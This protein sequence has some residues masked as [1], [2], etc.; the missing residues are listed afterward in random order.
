MHLDIKPA[1]IVCFELERQ[2]DGLRLTPS[3]WL[4]KADVNLKGAVETHRFGWCTVHWNCR[5]TK[6]SGLSMAICTCIHYM[7]S[8]ASEE[9]VATMQY[10]FLA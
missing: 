2:K 8:I 6:R 1:N 3:V 10:L 9:V 4:K 5:G 7:A